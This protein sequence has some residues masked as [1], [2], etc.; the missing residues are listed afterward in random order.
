[1]A[2]SPKVTG[3]IREFLS[4]VNLSGQEVPTF[5]NVMMELAMNDREYLSKAQTMELRKYQGPDK[6]PTEPEAPSAP[7]H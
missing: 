6:A 7:S 2:L 1:M 5:N 3:A 4:R